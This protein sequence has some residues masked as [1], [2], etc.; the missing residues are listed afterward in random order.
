M[1]LKNVTNRNL[2]CHSV[3]V[4]SI[5]NYVNNTYDTERCNSR[6]FTISSLHY[7]L[8]PIHTIMY[9]SQAKH[10]ALIMYSMP[11]TT[12]S[13]GT[14]QLISLT[15]LKLHLFQLVSLAETF[16]RCR[17]GGVGE[18]LSARRKPPMISRNNVY[19]IFIVTPNTT[20]QY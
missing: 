10:G 18:N 17:R 15:E 20:S 19:L 9:K 1:T 5:N 16:N 7:E 4:H 14:S 8:F 6:S 2:G 13:K 3:T 12:W 11:Y